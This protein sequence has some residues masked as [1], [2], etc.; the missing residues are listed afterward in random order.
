MADLPSPERVLD[1]VRSINDRGD[2]PPARRD[3]AKAFKVKGAER[4]ALRRLLSEMED[5]GLLVLEGKRAREKGV[6]PKV[7]VMDVIGTDSEGDLIA[8]PVK[9]E[10]GE[11]PQVRLTDRA[12]AS[13]TPPLGVGDRF[14]GRM[15]KR[16]GGF[17]A[18]PIKRLAQ[19]AERVLGVFEAARPGGGVVEP[20][21]RKAGKP[22]EIEKGEENSAK[23]GALVWAEPLPQ[24]GYGPRRARISE[25]VGAF[26]DSANWSLIA[27]ANQ[28]IPTEFPKAAIGEAKAATLPDLTHHEDIR[29]TPLVTIDPA[30]AKDHDDAVFAEKTEGGWRVLVA[31]ADVSWFVRPGSALDEE[32]KR[33][34]NSVYLVDRVVPMLPEALSNGLC[35]LHE[36]ED[37]TALV[38]EMHF[39]ED[40]Q[41]TKHRFFRAMMR[42]AAS[43]SYEEAQAAADGQPSERAR[44]LK[45]TV[46]DPLF[47]AYEAMS[48]AREKRSPLDLDLP[49]RKILLGDDGQ[50]ADVVLKE[51]FDAHKLI[52]AMMVAAN[53]C[54]AETLEKHRRTC[55]YRIH[56]AP[57]PERLDGL[58]QYLETLD[59]SLPK[60]QVL[61]PQSF[62]RILSKAEERDESDMVSMAVL[63]SQAQAK[64][65][66]VNVGH[67]GL[68]L[69]RY[70]HFTSPIRRYADLTVHRGIVAALKLGPGAERS[71]DAKDLP[72]VAEAISD[73]ERRAVAAERET[74]DRFLAA[75][76]QDKLGAEFAGRVNGVTRAGLFV[77]LDET[78]ADGFVPA[79]TL[80][81]EYFE[82]DE[83][84]NALIGQ[85]S[86]GRYRLG[87]RVRVGLV[88][89]T[90]LQGGLRFEMLSEPEAGERPG[91]KQ[92]APKK[93]AAPG[94]GRPVARTRSDNPRRRDEPP[95]EL[96]R[97]GKVEAPDDEPVIRRRP[98]KTAKKA[99]RPAGK[100][101][102]PPGKPPKNAA[103]KARAGRKATKKTTRQKSA[104]RSNKPGDA[105]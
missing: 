23:D 2:G 28:D 78:G 11:A 5:E 79:R 59:Y 70:A 15:H 69:A 63:R 43:L 47:A 33:R 4:A 30:D 94:K 9:W 74:Q 53:V 52:E 44:P 25:V 40:G 84:R 18:E 36:G 12:A 92:R 83:K 46:I 89:V 38:C 27:L 68:N 95:A 7:A 48:R 17:E 72:K 16:K 50:V 65:D 6:L 103:A 81:W 35:S 105:R 54:A 39:G 104:S 90:P 67:F 86:G 13:T 82:H 20:V 60:G 42:S 97:E 24:R 29:K 73:T 100:P 98:R 101:G 99:G 87:Q 10:D 3:I 61:K 62:N 21:S 75:F 77:T 22:L 85:K 49:E 76:L 26:G 71:D 34:G 66:T 93:A 58:R 19:R 96:A 37:R 41:K 91:R 14:L 102:K 1:Y 32:A 56:D 80:G 55:I 64:Y 8:R 51:R 31:I 57:A 45:K 88:E